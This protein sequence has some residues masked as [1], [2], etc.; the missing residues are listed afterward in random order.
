MFP[1]LDSADEFAGSSWLLT[2]VEG[3]DGIFGGEV[4]PHE[5]PFSFSDLSTSTCQP[6]LQH[7]NTHNPLTIPT[8]IQQDGYALNKIGKH[9]PSLATLHPRAAGLLDLYY[10]EQGSEAWLKTRME[11][12]I[13]S[14]TTIGPITGERFYSETADT[15]FDA[16][17]GL[18]TPFAGNKFTDWGTAFEDTAIAKYMAKVGV[19]VYSLGI[20]PFPE[21][22]GVGASPDGVRQ[23]GLLIEVK[24]PFSR[25]IMEID[26]ADMAA[27]QEQGGIINASPEVGPPGE[28]PANY[29]AQLQLGMHVMK[30]PTIDFIQFKPHANEPL[31][32]TL[33]EIP[34]NLSA[35]TETLMVTR[36]KAI[37]NWFEERR[38]MV[39]AFIKR[40]ADYRA[41]DPEWKERTLAWSAYVKAKRKYWRTPMP[42]I[43]A[44][45]IAR[46][47]GTCSL[48]GLHPELVR[49]FTKARA[50]Y[51]KRQDADDFKNK[52]HK[53]LNF[54]FDPK[55]C[56][57]AS[58][59]DTTVA[60]NFVNPFNMSCAPSTISDSKKR[61]ADCLH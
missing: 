24:C 1:Q 7:H 13:V 5:Q 31:L 6:T 37:P 27:Y 50:K 40:V 43:V 8:P 3:V 18:D 52:Y 11:D 12:I 42:Q 34:K 54:I 38:P 39:E 51:I 16:K 29:M 36:V 23:D 9:D 10:D 15:V 32:Q 19:P 33:A 44:D 47:T 20:V 61:K 4:I 60:T 49:V 14:G 56:T 59:T 2:D 22:P 41:Y 46:S 35:D 25:E 58:T 45:F 57:L 17:N 48:E 53:K 28:V 26:D 55:T 21:L 30:S